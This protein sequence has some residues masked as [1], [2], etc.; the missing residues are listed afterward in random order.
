MRH[1]MANGTWVPGLSDIDATI[2]LKHG[3]DSRDAFRAMARFWR[4]WDTVRRCFPVLGDI[5]VIRDDFIHA[6]T[7]FTIRG[8]EA[9]QWTCISGEHVVR[10]RYPA[11]QERLVRDA[12]DHALTHYL[13]HILAAFLVDKTLDAVALAEYRRITA[14]IVRY[15]Q[16]GEPTPLQVKPA[17]S[18]S[19]PEI[20]SVAL[21]ALTTAALRL[22]PGHATDVGP[23]S[24]GP[25]PGAVGGDKTTAA[26]AFPGTE[27]LDIENDALESVMASDGILYVV[28]KNDAAD[29]NLVRVLTRMPALAQS[30]TSRIVVFTAAL[31]DYYL[32]D[33]SP[34]RHGRLSDS[35]TVLIGSDPLAWCT[36]PDISSCARHI[37]K[38]TGFVLTYPYS[39]DFLGVANGDGNISPKSVLQRY[40]FLQLYLRKKSIAASHHQ[41]SLDCRDV[42][43]DLYDR[44]SQN[45]NQLAA[46]RNPALGLCVFQDLVSLAE[47]A[48][49]IV[50]TDAG[51]LPT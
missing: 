42:A 12:L 29:A 5:N 30:C 14:K 19:W 46:G 40:L 34:F 33:Y 17:E 36:A 38:Q 10:S 2:I 1:S 28:L 11:M 51:D 16:F 15:A 50:A 6:W 13:E 37:C 3:M 8:Y 27:L 23:T 7:R 25:P 45:L 32:Y 22:M 41:C 26:G 47:R 35:R 31:F 44:L 4:A 39:R 20:V 49:V 43:P 21:S 24:A 18:C 9:R 48:S